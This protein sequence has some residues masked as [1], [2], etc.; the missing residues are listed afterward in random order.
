[1]E[2]HL[3]K[4]VLCAILFVSA[5]GGSTTPKP[6]VV[7]VPT[8]YVGLFNTSSTEA[9]YLGVH[10]ID[11]AAVTATGSNGSLDQAS[12]A[13]TISGQSGNISAD[14]L[15]VTLNNGDILDVTNSGQTYVAAFKARNGS[16]GGVFGVE[17]HITHL[18]SGSASYSGSSTLTIIDGFAAFDLTGNSAVNVNFDTEN[19]NITYSGLNGRQTDPSNGTT[20]ATNVGTLS[21]NGASMFGNTFNGGSAV[22]NMPQVSANLTGNQTVTTSGGFFGP[23]ANE[24]G[25]VNL[26]DDTTGAG[27][28][29]ILG[30]FIGQ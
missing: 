30:T 14:R 18:P 4:P 7:P 29:L 13:F 12:N 23:T 24:V 2:N 28:L 6:P 21:I 11:S 22:L 3:G 15:T 1:M 27:S 17:T 9:S 25:G 26:I 8:S 10:T 20:T 5:C 16:S 19:V